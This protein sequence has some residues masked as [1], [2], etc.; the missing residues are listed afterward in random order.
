MDR[1]VA[2]RAALIQ[3][4]SLAVIAVVLAVEG[5]FY[6]IGGAIGSS[7][8]AAL[9]TGIFPKRLAK[10]LP[11]ETQPD[12]ML[13]YGDINK[14]TLYPKGSRTRMAI[15]A[16]Y[17]DAQMYMAI[18]STAVLIIAL[19]AVLMWRGKKLQFQCADTNFV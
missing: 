17:G 19:G 1:S 10:Y 2:L 18:V 14:Q 3:G 5:M 12:L 11:A 16:A 13:I 6:S 9:W 8:S 7:I 15:E 4:G